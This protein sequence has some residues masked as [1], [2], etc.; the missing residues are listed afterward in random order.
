MHK[1]QDWPVRD[2]LLQLFYTATISSVLTME[3]LAGV[4]CIQ[5]RQKQ[6]RQEHQGGRWGRGS[7]Q[8][9]ARKHR[10]SLSS[11]GAKQTEDHFGWQV[12][13]T[14]TWIWQRTHRSDRVRIPCSKTTRHLQSVSPT[15]SRAHGQQAARQTQH[16]TARDGDAGTMR[17]GSS[18]GMYGCE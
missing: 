2:E 12:A 16:T 13:P 17:L 4:G 8:E 1:A 6:T 3:W 18:G 11:I 15:A 10:H 9:K 14:Q 5:T 7:G